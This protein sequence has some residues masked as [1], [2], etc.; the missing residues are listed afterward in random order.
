MD[1]SIATQIFLQLFHQRPPG[2]HNTLAQLR[3]RITTAASTY[4]SQRGQ[5]RTYTGRVSLDRGMK[6]SDLRVQ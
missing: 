3:R 1:F 6:T 2:C 4:L 5:R